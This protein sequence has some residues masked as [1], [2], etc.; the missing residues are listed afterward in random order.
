MGSQGIVGGMPFS[1]G[2][3]VDVSSILHSTGSS[4]GGK[5]MDDE[6]RGGDD[7]KDEGEDDEEGDEDERG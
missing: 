1:Q 4:K 6:E 7:E 2:L 3:D 5:D